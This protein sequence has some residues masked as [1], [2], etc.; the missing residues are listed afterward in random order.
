MNQMSLSSINS[1]SLGRVLGRAVEDVHVLIAKNSILGLE[2]AGIADILGVD[3]QEVLDIEDDPSYRE[4]RVH[5]AA[6]YSSANVETDLTWDDIENRALQNI[7]K[8]VDYETDIETNLRIAAVANRATRRHKSPLNKTL[9]A[10]AV[11]EK[12]QLTLT[13]RVIERLSNTGM[14]RETVREISF[15]NDGI[16]NPTFE[17]VDKH[18]GVSSRP[19]IPSNLSFRTSDPTH[20]AEELDPDALSKLMDSAKKHQ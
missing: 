1:E 5:I 4:V 13:K 15:M 20:H 18:L 2:A 16:S 10:G 8:R 9:D 12:V 6:Q 3:V 19:R 14:E 17:D 11:G 7:A